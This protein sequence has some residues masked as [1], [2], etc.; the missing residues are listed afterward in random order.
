M[1]LGGGVQENLFFRQAIVALLFLVAHPPNIIDISMAVMSVN[2]IVFIGLLMKLR[3]LSIVYT[4]LV[5]RKS[6]RWFSNG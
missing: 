5:N 1:G 3:L 4:I 6:M 2:I